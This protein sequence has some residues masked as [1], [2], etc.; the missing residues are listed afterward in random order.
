MAR[1]RDRTARREACTARADPAMLRLTAIRRCHEAAGVMPRLFTGLEIPPQVAQSLVDD[2]RRAA[3]RALDR[4]GKLSPDVALHRRHRRRTGARDRQPARPRA[5]RGRSS[6][7]STGWPRSAA[8]SRAHRRRGRRRS[9]PLME[10]QAE[11]ER[12]MQRL[13]LEPEGRKYTPHVT[14]ARLR[15]SSSRQVADY[16]SA[17]AA[18]PFAAVRGRRASCCSRRAPRSAAGPTWSRR[19]IRSAYPSSDTRILTRSFRIGAKAPSPES[20]TTG[21]AVKT[22]HLGLWIPGSRLRRAP[23]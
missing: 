17:R 11:H 12:L 5:A 23:E 14:L 13:G 16:L 4:S 8:A 20:M 3:G 21:R 6:C 19:P 1:V 10:L 18:F 15:D 7:A 9:P 22:P 2:A